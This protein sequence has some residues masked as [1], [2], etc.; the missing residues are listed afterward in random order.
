M[1][2]DF[3]NRGYLLPPGCKDLIDALKL[4]VQTPPF[5]ASLIDTS[6]ITSKL[7]PPH[8]E[9]LIKK[10]NKLMPHIQKFE[11]PVLHKIEATAL[12]PV[13]GQL[14]VPAKTTVNG[15]AA[16]LG[17]KPFHIATDLLELRVMAAGDEVLTFD[18]ISKVARK[19]GFPSDSSGGVMET[20]EKL[21][22]GCF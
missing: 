4:N 7:T 2:Q 14:V 11:A 8:L 20:L 10:L 13:L 12:P 9:Q 22:R 15:L 16:L 18:V 17:R 6:A 3:M 21:R 1:E 19:Y 5:P